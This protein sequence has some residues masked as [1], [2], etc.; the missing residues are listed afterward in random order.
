MLELSVECK[1]KFRRLSN[2]SRGLE[3]SAL[4]PSPHWST[5]ARVSLPLGPRKN[6]VLT[7]R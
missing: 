6:Q 5:H 3:E 7:M 1:A 2:F 4:F